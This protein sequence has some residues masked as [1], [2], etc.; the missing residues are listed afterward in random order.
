MI[1]KFNIRFWYFAYVLLFACACTRHSDN[2]Y[3]PNSLPYK[4]T[5]VSHYNVSDDQILHLVSIFDTTKHRTANY[6]NIVRKN[7][8]LPDD[9]I[10][11]TLICDNLFHITDQTSFTLG[12]Y[13][14]IESVQMQSFT[15]DVNGNGFIEI[16]YLL[17]FKD[18]LVF[19]L[20]E[21]NDSLNNHWIEWIKISRED[22][23]YLSINMMYSPQEQENY[24][25]FTKRNRIKA[26]E[27]R[28]VDTLF[29]YDLNKRNIAFKIPIGFCT[30][31]IFDFSKH[32]TF[33]SW[34]PNNYLAYNGFSDSDSYIV[35]LNQDGSVRFADTI[36]TFMANNYIMNTIIWDGH[37]Y[38]IKDTNFTRR[39]YKKNLTSDEHFFI[40]ELYP[41]A[42]YWFYETPSKQLRCLQILDKAIT[43]YDEDFE[44]VSSKD[45]ASKIFSMTG[46]GVNSSEYLDYTYKDNNPYPNEYANFVKSDKNLSIIT[47]QNNQFLITDSDDLNIYA[48]TEKINDFYIARL[49]KTEVN[50]YLLLKNNK[51]ASIYKIEP[52]DMLSR[53]WAW[54]DIISIMSI[55]LIIPVIGWAFVRI[56]Y[57]K[58]LYKNLTTENS[59]YG[60]LVLKPDFSIKSVNGRFLS[61]VGIGKEIINYK[62]LQDSE[63]VTYVVG[64][65]SND[66]FSNDQTFKIND[67]DKVLQIVITSFDTLM[68]SHY[69]LITILD[70][71]QAYQLK[72]N[73]DVLST[74]LMITHNL[75]SPLGTA[76]LEFE[77]LIAEYEKTISLNGSAMETMKN[78]IKRSLNEAGDTIKGIIYIA[79][80]INKASKRIIIFKDY[81]EE[82]LNIYSSRYKARGIKMIVDYKNMDCEVE[83]NIQG[84]DL[85]ILA[86]CDNSAQAMNVSHVDKKILFY[87]QKEIGNIIFIIED[88]GSGM[89]DETI[90]EI[91]SNPGFTNRRTGSG[92]GFQLIKKVCAENDAVLRILSNKYSGTLIEVKLKIKLR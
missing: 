20:Y 14:G 24:L 78:T 84:F 3:H 52:N 2:F 48:A 86:I 71:T 25:V 57:H 8:S 88:N 36:S 41:H 11:T 42:S 43:A 89:G 50:E 9:E 59:E 10:L 23:H 70:I 6:I 77:N 21:L 18:S 29:L 46:M 33:T 22:R 73:S 5:P 64:L 1:S 40:S 38:Y 15:S 44:I 54:I 7:P 32:L 72:T 4:L 79:K 37:I 82:W 13:P 85:M 49:I 51:R 58:T 53:I 26:I 92:I 55:I 87:C 39:V 68:K 62:E 47:T 66:T 76:L 16:P 63:V 74:A 75:K 17:N 35:Q 27:K 45:F 19:G 90:A 12:K 34:A 80:E 56:D 83:I 28:T 30:T 69:Y 91:E 65:I 67:K 61:I 81:I 31:E 60:V